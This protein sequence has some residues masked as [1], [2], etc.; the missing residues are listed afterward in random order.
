MTKTIFLNT[1]LVGIS[2]LLL[3]AALFFGL[4]FTQ[5]QEETYNT[6]REEA[7][8]LETGLA[9]NGIDYFSAL[10]DVNRI[11]WID[12]EGEVLYDS[13]YPLPIP[14]EKNS[15]EVSMALQTGEGQ[16]IRKSASNGENTMYYARRCEDG[17]I[18]RLSRPMARVS[19]ALLAVSPIAWI[20]VLVLVISSVLAFRIAKQIVKPINE[21]DLDHPE[22][23]IYPEL[24]PLVSRIQ[25]QNFTIQEQIGELNRRQK[26]FSALTDSMQEGF[27]L[28][29]SQGVILSANQSA[30]RLAEGL[31]VGQE[32]L[33]SLSG[34]L[35][36]TVK[37]ALK[38]KRGQSLLT[39]DHISW[40]LTAGPVIIHGQISGAVLLIVDVTEREQREQLRQEFSA[41]VSHEL[42]TPLTSISG[43]AE[44]LSS[45]LAKEERVK[46]FAGDIYRESQRLI[47]LV[48]DIIKVSRLDE[49]GSMPSPENVQLKG[50]CEDILRTL[51]PVA[52]K[53]E[54]TMQLVGED[55]TLY[56]VAQVLDEIIYNLCDNAIKYNKKGGLVTV[57][58]DHNDSEAFL[59]VEDTGIGIPFAHQS[60]VFER[61]YRVNKSHSKEIGGTGLG[62]SIVKHGAQYL[63]AK[64]D[65]HSEPGKGTSIRLTIPLIQEA[66]TKD[67]PHLPQA[68]V[69]MEEEQA[70]EEAKRSAMD[71]ARREAQCKDREPESGRA[72]DAQDKNLPE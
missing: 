67:M 28:I 24:A 48:D 6:L 64:I 20:L 29:D 26:E 59:T 33:P 18:L 8:Y 56:V 9:L 5:V 3:C 41:N 30:L 63:K 31:E 25:V 12:A 21:L 70:L 55:V 50:M 1:F 32:I 53:Q 44:L 62:L 46:E 43:F 37:G 11:T 39:V 45:G 71:E 14:N 34:D 57:A 23:E 66:K 61:F 60:R 68:L 22:E 38:G 13:N 7:E 10:S 72:E 36:E 49:E 27:L 54:V 42:K 40:E 4:Q 17:T 58:L 65:L 52:E 2:V 47:A 51:G 16:G 69:P 35:A 19:S 15:P